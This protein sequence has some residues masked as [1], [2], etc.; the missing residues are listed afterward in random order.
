MTLNGVLAGLVGVTAVLLSASGSIFIGLICGVAVVFSI[1]FID[2]KLKLTILLAFRTRCMWCLRY[3][4]SRCFL[5]LMAD[6]FTVVD[7]KTRSSGWSIFNCDMGN[8]RF[9]SSFHLEENYGIKR[10][11]RGN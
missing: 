11:R 4:I 10:Q 9:Y 7:L 8:G 2:K 1:E 5:L 3:F 6:Y